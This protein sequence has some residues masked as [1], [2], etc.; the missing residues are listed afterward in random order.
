MKTMKTLIIVDV[1]NDFIPGGALAVPNGDEIVPIINALHGQFDLVVATQDWHPPDHISFASNHANRKPFDQ[2]DLNG[3]PQTLWPDHCVQ[4]MHG[5]AFHPMLDLEPA[6]AIFRK[7]MDP[8][9]DSYSGFFDNGHQKHTGLAGYLREKEATDLYFCGLAAEICV[10][11]TVKD[12]MELGFTATLIEDATRP[13][14]V[15]AFQRA[16]R[17]LL[18]KGAKIVSSVSIR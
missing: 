10:A 2:I 17:D 7:G 15:K 16:K 3:M 9:I 6:E 5:A 14:D 12:A 11:F 1:Q 4:S 8:G 18:N 13:L